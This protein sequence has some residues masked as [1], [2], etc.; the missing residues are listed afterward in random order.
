MS[1]STLLEWDLGIDVWRVLPRGVHVSAFRT[2]DSFPNPDHSEPL[3]VLIATRPTT[4]TKVPCLV[5]LWSSLEQNLIPILERSTGSLLRPIL[6]SDKSA[7]VNPLHDR[8]DTEIIYTFC[9]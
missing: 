9:S 5:A 7:P 6:F 3:L 4:R 1:R 8:A 2:A